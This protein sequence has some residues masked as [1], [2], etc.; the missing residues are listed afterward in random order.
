MK[1]I[2]YIYFISLL[3]LNCDKDNNNDSNSIGELVVNNK[4]YIVHNVVNA[5]FDTKYKTFY[6]DLALQ[7]PVI[8]TPDVMFQIST[9]R[10][11][12][13]KYKL[14]DRSTDNWSTLIFLP[15]DD[16]ANYANL[17]E[18]YLEISELDEVNR[19]MKVILSDCFYKK[20][21]EGT[22]SWLLR[23]EVDIKYDVEEY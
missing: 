10:L 21:P 8:L 9:Q 2:I 11:Q 13:G 17:I 3:L 6:F 23:G 19:R 7:S 16:Q 12:V 15:N 22:L 18:G 14:G 20:D 1:R 4:T 5:T